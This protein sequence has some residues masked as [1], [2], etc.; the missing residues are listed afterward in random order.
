MM[1]FTLM[2]FNTVAQRF[3]I[4]NLLDHSKTK[5]KS[6]NCFK[7]S[8]NKIICLRFKGIKLKNNI[9]II[10]EAHNLLE[11]IGQMYSSEIT[12]NQL[13]IAEE[14]L[15]SYRSKFNSRFSAENLLNINQLIFVISSLF[16]FLGEQVLKK[17]FMQIDKYIY[18]YLYFV[19]K[20]FNKCLCQWC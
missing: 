10:D 8:N 15:K 11:A 20:N 2:V 5:L 3:K 18:Y 6:L 14:L 13:F 19:N 12:Y 4:N 7:V 16:K 1:V 9:V 17:L